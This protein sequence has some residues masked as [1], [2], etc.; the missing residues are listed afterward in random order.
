MQATPD[1]D[2]SHLVKKVENE[3]AVALSQLYDFEADPN[4]KNHLT[5]AVEKF[6]VNHLVFEE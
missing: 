5:G 3:R 4:K 2:V 1:V 6:N